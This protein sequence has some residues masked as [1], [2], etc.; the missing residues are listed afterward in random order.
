MFTLMLS[1]LSFTMLLPFM[2]RLSQPFREDGAKHDHKLGT[3]TM[4]GVLIIGGVLIRCIGQCFSPY[5]VCL[6]GFALL[7]FYDDF[8]KVIKGSSHGVRPAVKFKLQLILSGLVVLLL[9][10]DTMLSVFGCQVDIGWLYYPFAVFIMVATS[11]A[12]NLTDGLDGLAATQGLVLLCF[13]GLYAQSQAHLSLEF[14][15]AMSIMLLTFLVY[16]WHPAAIFMGDVGSLSVGAFLG[17][18]AIDLKLEFYFILPAMV[19]IVEVLSVII[20][21]VS[22]KQGYGRVFKMAPIHHHYELLGYS[23]R[24]IVLS[25]LC[26]TAALSGLGLWLL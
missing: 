25:C 24:C 9:Q 19:M 22:Y 18:L 5:W 6:L 4:G 20:Q 8:L 15:L 14:I 12:F 3:P 17:L 16:N 21:V 2:H 10:P 1:L 11:N 7:G 23:E 26:L 13:F